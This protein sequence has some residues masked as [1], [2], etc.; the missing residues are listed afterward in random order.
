[1]GPGDDGEIGLGLGFSFIDVRRAGR[2]SPWMCV[3]RRGGVRRRLTA[4]TGLG[5]GARSCGCHKHWGGWIKHSC[6]IENGAEQG[7]RAGDLSES[8][9]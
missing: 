7:A 5:M 6:S 3:L 8:R 4:R 1:M 2:R 9:C